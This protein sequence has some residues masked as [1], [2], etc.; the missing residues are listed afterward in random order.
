MMLNKPQRSWLTFPCNSRA[1]SAHRLLASRTE[2]LLNQLL[3]CNYSCTLSKA[4]SQEHAPSIAGKPFSESVTILPT[5]YPPKRGSRAVNF[6][7]ASRDAGAEEQM[8]DSHIL[9][10]LENMVQA[11]SL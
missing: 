6:W 10:S 9:F 1:F 8:K 7:A 2:R 5:L 3:S 4:T 11:A